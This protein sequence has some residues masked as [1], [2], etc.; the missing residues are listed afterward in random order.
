MS[1]PCDQDIFGL[2]YEDRARLALAGDYKVG[3][4][5]GETLDDGDPYFDFGLIST[6]SVGKHYFFSTRNNAF[7]NRDQ[8]AQ[9]ITKQ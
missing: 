2:D 5:P 9:V 6:K 7:T 4:T 1:Y 8:K 3:E